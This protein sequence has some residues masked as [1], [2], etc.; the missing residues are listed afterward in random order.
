MQSLQKHVFQHKNMF[1]DLVPKQHFMHIE[2][3]VFER[4]NM[5]LKGNYQN[6]FLSV[7]KSKKC[8]KVSKS[9]FFCGSWKFPV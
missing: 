4:K 9:M 8:T 6:M 5:F 7:H 2:K 1:L 3:Y